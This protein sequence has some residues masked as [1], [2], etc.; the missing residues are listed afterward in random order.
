MP[1][2]SIN[3]QINV[4]G[5]SLSKKTEVEVSHPHAFVE[6]LPVG[7]AGT[8]TA[9][10]DA[11]TG[12]AT[13]GADHGI[14][15]GM[16]VDVRWA[17]GIRYGMTV[18]TVASLV[19]PLDGGAGDDLPTT[20][21]PLVVSEQV[22]IN[23]PI[24]GDAVKLASIFAEYDHPNSTA[25]AH[26]NLQ[27]S[28]NASIYARTLNANRPRNY[29]LED[30]EDANPF[31]GNPITQCKASNGSATEECDLHLLFGEDASP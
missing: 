17:A 3:S 22:A 5:V 10:T 11:N 26:V 8:L 31:T 27:D 6:T 9:R 12:S 2:V 21:T 23:T 14:T 1:L 15:D 25:K 28:G 29:D 7:K 13:L 30:G 16:I 18:G 24:D 4:A 20:T 19:V